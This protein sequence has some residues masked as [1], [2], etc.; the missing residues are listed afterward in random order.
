M[1]CVLGSSLELDGK[2]RIVVGRDTFA[3]SVGHVHGGVPVGS[4][5][6]VGRY[7]VVGILEDLGGIKGL[8]SQNILAIVMV[9][10]SETHTGVLL[11]S[12]GCETDS[13]RICS[14]LAGD[15]LLDGGVHVVGIDSQI[16]AVNGGLESCE[17][18][19]S[20][21]LCDL[22]IDLQI[23]TLREI[24]DGGDEADVDELVLRVGRHEIYRLLR[25]LLNHKVGVLEY[26]CRF[27]EGLSRGIGQ[28]KVIA[29][30]HDQGQRNSRQKFYLFHVDV[31]VF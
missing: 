27:G 16:I 19:E 18:L 30:S 13:D 26:A 3:G 25:N 8:Y 4:A 10:A 15:Y 6:G 17:V 11:D 14:G 29:G 23:I 21:V 22:H 24:I 9:E 7:E 31:L 1:I 28:I 5:G 20:I 12:I 2:F